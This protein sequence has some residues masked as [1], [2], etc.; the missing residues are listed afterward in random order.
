[1][2][3]IELRLNK[4]NNKLIVNEIPYNIIGIAMHTETEQEY[5]ILQ[6]KCSYKVMN[7]EILNALE[8]LENNL[9]INKLVSKTTYPHRN[10]FQHYKNKKYY[11]LLAEVDDIFFEKKY[12]LYE[13]LY[14]SHKLWIRPKEMFF[15]K[16]KFE[17][18]IVDRFSEIKNETVLRSL[19]KSIY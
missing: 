13:S 9:T 16:V 1:M 5:L 4:K 2:K 14:D 10:I 6:S 8:L 19:E 15:S 3:D 17:N 12:I 7:L 11:R 18:K